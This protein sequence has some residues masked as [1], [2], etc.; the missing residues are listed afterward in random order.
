MNDLGGAGPALPAS[1][2]RPCRRGGER[3]AA[4]ISAATIVVFGSDSDFRLSR[5]G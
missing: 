3:P 5:R 2:G 4:S 1:R